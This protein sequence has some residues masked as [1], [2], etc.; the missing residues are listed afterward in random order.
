MNKKSVCL[1][2]LIM[3]AWALASPSSA[4]NITI[5][6]TNDSL[7]NSYYHARC[8]NGTVVPDDN[9]TI[10]AGVGYA[11][12][13]YSINRGY[14]K[15]PLG[16]IPKGSTITKAII[17]LWCWAGDSWSPPADHSTYDICYV[18][19]DTWSEWSITWDNQPGFSSILSSKFFYF[20]P[21]T[22]G[23][24]QNWLN[25]E[26]VLNG[27]GWNYAADLNDGVLSV[28]VK[29]KTE[30]NSTG[31]AIYWSKEAG[32]A[33]TPYLYVE[34]TPPRKPDITGA[35]GLLLLD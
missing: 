21:A 14:F 32:I 13:N 9:Q 1:G 26:L 33:Y 34:Y 12:G 18:V 35:R 8:Y 28:A 29:R 31:V 11:Y 5:K 27:A 17:Y 6:A 24:V 19:N 16:A 30:E 15:F 4:A 22:G 20:N 10:G 25:W 2:V 23:S 3:I 7:V